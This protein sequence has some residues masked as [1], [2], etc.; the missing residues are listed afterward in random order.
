MEKWMLKIWTIIQWTLAGMF[1]AYT[2]IALY[3]FT[4]MLSHRFLL[5]MPAF[6]WLLQVI[7]GGAVGGFIAGL[8]KAGFVE[9][10][11]YWRK[12]T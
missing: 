12:K 10:V 8:A 7:I 5:G 4:L 1:S 6:P 9:V 3:S 11:D 2:V